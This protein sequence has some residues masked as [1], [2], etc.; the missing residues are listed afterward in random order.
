M[1][2]VNVDASGQSNQLLYR[3]IMKGAPEYVIASC[4]RIYDDVGNTIPFTAEHNAMLEQH[5]EKMGSSGYRMIGMA[6]QQI[7]PA[8]LD[9]YAKLKSVT[10]KYNGLPNTNYIFMGLISLWDPPREE[11]EPALEICRGAQIRVPMCQHKRWQWLP[12]TSVIKGYRCKT[13]W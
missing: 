7:N 3:C 12:F 1:I 6:Q 13:C 10:P 2:S 4:D 9:R 5:Q 8:E 11:V